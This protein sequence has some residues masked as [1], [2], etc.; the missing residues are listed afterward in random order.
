[1]KSLE[2]FKTKVLDKSQEKM[3]KGG[4]VQAGMVSE[5]DTLLVNSSNTAQVVV[6]QPGM[7]TDGDT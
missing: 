7:I 5:S 6:I 3:I 1:M 2:K 4:V